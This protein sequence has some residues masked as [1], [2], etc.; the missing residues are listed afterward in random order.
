[1][2]LLASQEMSHALQDQVLEMRNL[3]Y[4]T[5][6]VTCTLCSTNQIYCKASSNKGN[7]KMH[8]PQGD[9]IN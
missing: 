9:W 3:L 4:I 6:T 8:C 5:V 7:Q 2:E 1:M